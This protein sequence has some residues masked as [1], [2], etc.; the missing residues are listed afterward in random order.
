MNATVTIRPANLSDNAALERLAQLD[1]SHVPE[2]NLIVAYVGDDL[3]AAMPESGGPA[4]ADPF[5]Y[6]EE[7]LDAIKACAGDDRARIRMRR[8]SVPTALRLA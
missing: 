7:L 1:S 6:T 2:G 4:I 8:R 5:H 3:R